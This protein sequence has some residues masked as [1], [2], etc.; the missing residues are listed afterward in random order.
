MFIQID[1]RK[2]ISATAG[3]YQGNRKSWL[4]RAAAKCG[5]TPSMIKALYYGECSDPKVS[6]ALGVL[7]AAEK[8]RNEAGALAAKFEMAAGI[9]NE[10]NENLHSDDVLTLLGAARALRGVDTAG[11]RVKVDTPEGKIA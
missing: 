9:L 11:S 3:P 1:W 10:R 2:E 5:T 8:A 6:V 7:S 4:A